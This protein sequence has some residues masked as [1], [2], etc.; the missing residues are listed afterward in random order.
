[1][2]EFA[3]LAS[4]MLGR[5]FDEQVAYFRQKL[6]N[7]VPTQTWTDMMGQSHDTGF[8]VAGAMKADLLSDL[9][10]AVDRAIAEGTSLDAFRKDFQAIVE[11]N[12]WHDYT[13]SGSAAGIAWRTRTIYATNA[14]TSYAA[15]REAQL[16]QAGYAL[17]VYR[18][19]DTVMHPRVQHLAWDGLTLPADHPF[20]AT[21]SP[22]NGWGCR[23]YKVGARSAAGARRLGGDPG[24]PLPP[25]WD[26]VDPRTG[27]PPGI[28]RGWGHAPGA[29]VADTVA[30]LAEK[31][32]NWD[33]QLSLAFMR[34]LP[35]DRRDQLARSYRALPSLET[36][37]R[38]YAE[39]AIGERGGAPIEEPS[40]GVRPEIAPIRT[41][42]LAAGPDVDRLRRLKNIDV[43][44]WD[45]VVDPSSVRH[46][47]A[48]HGNPA[49][50]DPRGQ[51]AVTPA[52][53]GRLGA[54]FNEPDAVEDSGTDDRG[55]PAV[56]L[57]KRIG[58]E[59]FTVVLSLL[60]SRRSLALTTMY[61]G[62]NG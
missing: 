4:G 6:G 47:I 27:S 30:A 62:K 39:R 46:V 32:V 34:D 33:R 20:W 35:P 21:H 3:S 57:R 55:R 13:G 31:A 59:T 5:P 49:M 18:H 53:F 56:V 1:M 14:A 61:V 2:A 41:L 40:P 26:L 37:M 16:R 17:F 50:E 28:D 42:G 7:L 54:I 8:M 23:C 58:S 51:R 36:S 48:A 38:N 9:A 22:P 43:T 12:G 29:S 24:K 25:G 11:R 15:G 10:A 44:G 60:G 19:N 52:D 45:Y